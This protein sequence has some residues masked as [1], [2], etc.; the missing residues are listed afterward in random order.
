MPRLAWCVLLSSAAAAGANTLPGAAYCTL[1]VLA[2]TPPWS[3]INASY[4]ATNA[5]G[6]EDGIVVRRA[7]GGFSMIAAAMYGDPLW[8]RMR[9]DVFR[10]ADGLSWAKTRSLRVS[11]ENFNG[12]S[13]HSSSWGPFF[14]FNPANNSGC[15][16]TSATAA[17]PQIRVAG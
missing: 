1:P 12:S 13:P 17:R 2:W 11:D 3:I 4:D 15:S 10:S 6:L 9:L 5:H 16:A 14:T 7:D 8:V